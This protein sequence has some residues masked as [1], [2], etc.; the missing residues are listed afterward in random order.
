MTSG[1]LWG[2]AL[3]WTICFCSGQ[4]KGLQAKW[5]ITSGKKLIFLSST[6]PLISYFPLSCLCLV[7]TFG[8]S[9]S[10]PFF[11]SFFFADS[12]F[13]SCTNRRDCSHYKAALQSLSSMSRWNLLLIGVAISQCVNQHPDMT[14]RMF[15]KVIYATGEWGVGNFT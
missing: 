8:S 12:L 1:G 13:E 15:T 9:V 11:F 4:G 10:Q 5:K 14:H 6:L 7:Y 2:V 3:I